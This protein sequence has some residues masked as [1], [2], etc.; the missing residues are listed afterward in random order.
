MMFADPWGGIVPDRLWVVSE[1][2]FL[3]Q[4]DYFFPDGYNWDPLFLVQFVYPA[5]K[6]FL[7]ND[8]DGGST[9]HG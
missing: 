4:V 2:T 9:V 5:K 8:V 7:G 6:R 1:V 3:L